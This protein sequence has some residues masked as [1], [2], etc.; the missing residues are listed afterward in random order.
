MT[1][2][3]HALYLYEMDYQEASIVGLCTSDEKML[4]FLRDS[5]NKEI[6]LFGEISKILSNPISDP[7]E[8]FNLR[9][10]WLSIE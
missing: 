4:L 8:K 10:K 7:E 6:E 5:D 9:A 1:I 2:I 3:D